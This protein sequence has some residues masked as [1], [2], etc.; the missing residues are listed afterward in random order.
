MNWSVSVWWAI[1]CT[2]LVVAWRYVRLQERI[3][4]AQTRRMREV[5]DREAHLSEIERRSTLAQERMAAGIK[6]DGH[7]TQKVEQ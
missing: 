1:A 7:V 6:V 4:D 5:A 2:A 3:F